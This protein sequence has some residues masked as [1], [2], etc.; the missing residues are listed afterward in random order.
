MRRREFIGLVGGAAGWPLTARAQGVAR[1]P[2]ITIW[3]GRPNDAE[4]QR[5]ATVFFEQLEA[6]GWSNGHNVRAD[7]RWATSDMDRSSLARDIVE[8]HPDVIVAQTTPAVA[9]LARASQTAIRFH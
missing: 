6:L 2:Q 1:M 7:Y 3:M 9:A 4:G 8:Q 5:R